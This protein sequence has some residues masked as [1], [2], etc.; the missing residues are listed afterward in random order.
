MKTASACAVTGCDDRHDAKGHPDPAE[1]FWTYVDKAGPGNCWLWTGRLERNGYARFRHDGQRS[2][3]H[4]Y[5]YELEVGPIPDGLTIDHLCRVRHCVNPMHLEPVSGRENTRR[6]E[7][8]RGE[9]HGGAILTEA[10][11][12]EIKS[13]LR[14][15]GRTQLS[16]ATD[17]GVSLSTINHINTGRLWAHVGVAG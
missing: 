2:G 4:R 13:L 15:G 1:R 5:A 12:V 17:Y 9:D 11:V 16:L 14:T 10:D 3:A 6:R 7:D 8:L